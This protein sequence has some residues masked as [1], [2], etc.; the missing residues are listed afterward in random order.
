MVHNL[1]RQVE[2]NHR[3]DFVF[4]DL[5]FEKPGL[6]VVAWVETR[7][8]NVAPVTTH[9]ATRQLFCGQKSF[10]HF[11]MTQKSLTISDCK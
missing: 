8:T 7:T 5:L 2:M 10:K 3:H 6:N 11:L 9:E 1:T 4:E